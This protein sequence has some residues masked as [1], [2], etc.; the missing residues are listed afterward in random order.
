MI[1]DFVYKYIDRAEWTLVLPLIYFARFY[2]DK[3]YGSQLVIEPL[4]AMLSTTNIFLHEAFA[5]IESYFI[6]LQIC[7]QFFSDSLF[8]P[9]P[10]AKII[11]S[12]LTPPTPPASLRKNLSFCSSHFSFRLLIL[13]MPC[14]M[15]F[16]VTANPAFLKLRWKFRAYGIGYFK[17]RY[18]SLIFLLHQTNSLGISGAILDWPQCTHSDPTH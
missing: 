11:K 9:F 10:W 13:Y 18:S 15:N 3:C 2:L 8:P 16:R 7:K 4:C 12:S 17:F 6:A 5:L 1:L 14:R